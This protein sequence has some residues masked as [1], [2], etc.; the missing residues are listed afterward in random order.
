MKPLKILLAIAGSAMLLSPFPLYPQTKTPNSTVHPRGTYQ[1]LKVKTGLWE[2]VET[3]K[4]SGNLPVPE[5]VLDTLTPEQRARFEARVNASSSANSKVERNRYCVTSKDLEK[6]FN[7]DNKKCTW[8]IRES[9]SARA[10]G[11]VSCNESGMKMT[12]SG[13]FEAL[14]QEHIRGTAHLVS[15]G[16]GNKMTTDVTFASK[17]LKPACGR[18]Q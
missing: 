2:K 8:T 15:T 9:T 10:K 14:D 12:G 3:Y 1:P 7:F 6:P 5:G 11:S 4:I 18:V 16:N 13:D 17:W